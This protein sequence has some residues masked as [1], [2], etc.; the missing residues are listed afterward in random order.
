V[1]KHR[2]SEIEPSLAQVNTT[3]FWSEAVGYGRLTGGGGNGYAGDA[4]PA[5]NG[6]NA[7]AEPGWAAAPEEQSWQ[8]WQY[9][10]NWG[11]PPELHPDH[12][13]APVP[14]IR[15]T[16]DHPS[17]PFPAPRLQDGPE[18]AHRRPPGPAR[19]RSAPPQPPDGGH[20]HGNRRL[21][22]VPDEARAAHRV[23]PA[24]ASENRGDQFPRQTADL[25]GPPW[26]EATGF[27][28]QP[29]PAPRYQQQARPDWREADEYPPET[30]PQW[31]PG[32]ARKVAD[33]Q[34]AQ[35]A[36]EAWDYAVAIRD[37]AERE[38]AAITQQAASRADQITQQA[39]SRADQITQ[40]AASRAEELTQQAAGQATAIREAAEREA[41]ELRARLDSMSGE[42]SRVAAYVT[43]NLTAPAMPAAAMPVT[44]P[45]F[46]DSGPP[47][48]DSGP[49][50]LPRRT[51]SRPA[52]P[53]TAP[54]IRPARPD[55]KPARPRTTPDTER[56]R[57]R[58]TPA[59]KPQQ[60][61]RQLQAMRIASY[62]TA[63]LL[64]FAVAT[65]A[66]E[67]GLHGFKFFTFREAGVG[68]TSGN[69]TDQQF[70]AQ[71]A[72]A[73]HHAAA[74]KGRHHKKAHPTPEVHHS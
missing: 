42:L 38:A 50:P 12:P 49:Q 67:I 23:A 26:R 58:A 14:R 63:T 44:A 43:E 7:A 73:T 40:Q 48:P 52:R 10:Q 11:P 54:G 70:L 57:P 71:K 27:Q 69:E 29:G 72:A 33:G 5:P 56:A 6:Y 9:W 36:Q 18:V 22:A 68:Q 19:P 4:Y 15:F 30:A 2:R 74:P 1:S 65:G 32:R 66:T 20:G 53:D 39:A 55:I 8:E 60:R 25:A 31:A 45:P 37:A 24:P 51:A 47:F 64:A 21:Y 16:D 28:H 61:P 62:A 3:E 35:I 41:T 17:G 13:S 59:T 34:A 46:P